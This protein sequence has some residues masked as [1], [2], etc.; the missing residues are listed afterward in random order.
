MKKSSHILLQIFTGTYWLLYILGFSN[1]DFNIKEWDTELISIHLLILLFTI[2]FAFTFIRQYFAGITLQLWNFLV[3]VFALTLW[4][5]AGMVL[6]LAAP[7]LVLGVFLFYSGLV[8]RGKIDTRN[9]TKWEVILQALMVNYVLIS[10]LAT[11]FGPNR[12]EDFNLWEMPML[13]IPLFALTL[14]AIF[15]LSWK[16][17]LA[18]GVLLIIWYALAYVFNTIYPEVP[19]QEGPILLF[20]LPIL[21]QGV[22]YVA[23]HVNFIKK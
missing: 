13:I 6:L 14:L 16:H 15:A 21:V 23:Y 9:K 1:W 17:K 8:K 22:L 5:E 18:S 7:V 12:P 20:G 11:F 19:N 2:G 10:L 4:T 3:W